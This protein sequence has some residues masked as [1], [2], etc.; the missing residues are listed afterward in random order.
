MGAIMNKRL[1]WLISLFVVLGAV[2]VFVIQNNKSNEELIAAD[3]Y[4]G[5][6]PEETL[7]L[8]IA[9]LRESDMD[10]AS[11][12]FV[13]DDNGKRDIW[14]E[15]LQHVEQEDQVAQLIEILENVQP[16]PGDSTH[17]GDFKY[18]IL[19]DIGLVK[20]TINLELNEKTGVWKIESM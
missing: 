17:P 6:T 3:V 7:Q 9:A 14:L 11:K 13:L 10:L 12:Y 1:L 20:A 8:F 18:V 5:T 2:F 15:A 19:D 4:G 16:N